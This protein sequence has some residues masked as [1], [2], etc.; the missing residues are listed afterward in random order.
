MDQSCQKEAK[1]GS[2]TAADHVP[3][4][5][6]SDHCTLLLKEPE[7]DGDKSETQNH[8]KPGYLYEIDHI[9]LP[10]RTPVHLRSI[11]VAMV[12]EKTEM[13]VAVRYPSM[14][15]LRAFFNYSKRETH[16]ALDEKFVM[17]IALAEK[18]LIRLVPA[19]IFSEQKSL[20]TFWLIYSCKDNI[21]VARKKGSCLSD[22]LKGNGIVRWGI[23]RQVKYLGRHKE[24]DDID[25]NAQNSSSSFIN[26]IEDSQMELGHTCDERESIEEEKNGKDDDEDKEE[27][28]DGEE[29]EENDDDDDDQENEDEEEEEEDDDDDEKIKES[30]YKNLKRKRYSFRN[31][32]VKKPKK[33]NLQIKK[34]KHK[35]SQN[36]KNKGRSIRF[37]EAL[38][39]R[40]PKDRWSAER[41][42]LAEQNLLMVMKSKGATAE[43]PILRPQLRAEARKRIGDTGLLDHLLKHMAGKLAPGGEERF[44]R[45]HNPDGA[46]EYWLESADLV[47]IRRDAGVTD[48]YWVPPPGWKPGDSPTQDPVCA[49][50]LKL[51]K[52]DI[53][54]IKRDLALMATK[55]QLEE[56]VGKLRRELDEISSKRRQKENQAI[57]IA[58]SSR[59]DISQKL[60]QLTTSLD[61]SKCDF[62]SGHVPV[63]RYKEQLM[64]ISDFVKEIEEKIGKSIPPNVE[65]R[66]RKDSPLMAPTDTHITKEKRAVA[67]CKQQEVQA[68]IAARGET[69]SEIGKNQNN[70]Q[71]VAASE[72]EKTTAA[73]EKAAKIQRMKSGFRI[74]KPQGTFLWPNMVKDNIN[75]SIN[76]NSSS[77][78]MVQ[79]EVP[80][81]PSVSSSTASAPPQLPNY[82]HQPLV[83]PLAEKR[84]VKVTVSTVSNGPNYEDGANDYS[85]SAAALINLNDSPTKLNDMPPLTQMS[86]SARTS[87]WES[88]AYGPR[89]VMGYDKQEYYN[90]TCCCS[91]SATSLPCEVGNWL[92][93]STLKSAS[94]ES[95]HG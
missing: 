13:N 55:M 90:M 59:S 34:Q 56:E 11:R 29:D 1:Q 52:D 61:S 18:V 70:G 51:L 81:P 28:D 26:G 31:M 16:P 35:K 5:P 3:P 4:P 43:N 88:G 78:V 40:D 17:G 80:T 79:V 30:N 6:S 83:K 36:K 46:M 64:A 41:Y 62:G 67:K 14:E 21:T 33:E 60:D 57:T 69:T 77:Q 53:T 23:R 2:I 20:E 82:G 9:H 95:A 91:S 89:N 32:G 27:K 75:T 71:N 86:A 94:D 92:A 66:A 87:P 73:E 38:V 19:E 48:P 93:L 12:C 8:I 7:N 24:S 49:R 58:S 42:K 22:A 68:L 63:E 76:I 85:T 54:K 74:C 25:V 65:K 50:E 45:R 10:P 72:T 37:K 47:N 84:A 44:R 15:S 39:L